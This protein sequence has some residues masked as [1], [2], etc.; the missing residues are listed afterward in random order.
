L[1]DFIYV[2]PL[3]NNLKSIIPQKSE[4]VYNYFQLLKN[5]ISGLLSGI[6]CAI[7]LKSVTCGPI[8]MTL[9]AKILEHMRVEGNKLYRPGIKVACESIYLTTR[10]CIILLNFPRPSAPS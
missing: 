3:G 7:L 4:K 1:L 10:Y 6:G 5:G 2:L 9:T 8:Y